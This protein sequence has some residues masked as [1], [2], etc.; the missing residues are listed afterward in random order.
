MCFRIAML[1]LHTSPLAPL[2]RT[3]DAGG[4]NVYVRELSRE[5]GHGTMYVDIFTRKSDPTLPLVQWIN[6]R[7]RLIHIP[8][9][10]AAPLPPT[11][12]Y[13]YV[14]EF[15]RR[16]ERFAE[17]AEHG[18]DMVHSHYWLS[19]AAGLSLARDW[20]VPH[21]TMFHT[22]E[23]LKGQ[24]Y[25]GASAGQTPASLIRIEQEGRIA[26]MV[27]R[28]TVSTEHEGESLRQLYTLP[29]DMFSVIPCG[30]DLEVF[31]PGTQAERRAARKRIAPGET[32]VL[33]FVGRLD[34]IKGI[35][36][37]LESVAHMRT[38]ARLIVV[39]G[40]PTG[41]PEVERLRTRAAELGIG[42]RVRFP[43]AV[44]QEQL[45]DYYRAADVQVVTSRYE[46]FGLVAVEAL[47]SG[48]PVVSSAV[49]GLTSIVRDGENGLLVRWRC[50]ESFAGRLDELLEDDALRSRLATNARPSVE[51]FSW[52]RIGDEVRGMYA[53]LTADQRTVAACS[54][55]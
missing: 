27:D 35:D 48:T 22:V 52:Q 33:L 23:R 3:R 13:P 49:G 10:P 6:E 16:V 1:S 45:K 38:P 19:A 7:V 41:D 8:A 25:G 24:Q 46:S 34:P 31:T 29:V 32:P 9:G 28:I 42:G 39:G 51:R 30:V 40:D 14:D 55:F 18:Y 12:L 2:G 21:V 53:E 11:E 4:M 26:A 47:A 17:R 44:Q 43:G 54:C 50:A 37:L 20:N 36:L 15:A 5:L